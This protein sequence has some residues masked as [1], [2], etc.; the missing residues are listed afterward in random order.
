VNPAFLEPIQSGNTAKVASAIESDHSLAVCRDEQNV[1]ALLWSVYA[2]HGAVRN[3]LAAKLSSWQIPLDVF[4][5]AATGD[6]V[7]LHA[8]LSKSACATSAYSG[9]RWTAPHL[10]AAFGTPLSV[11]TLIF[12]GRR[13]TQFHKTSGGISQCMR[14]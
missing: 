10:T 13:S 12:W 1:S 11:A 4:E 14:R 3:L 7:R 5:A 9:Y 2:G 6:Q 8:I